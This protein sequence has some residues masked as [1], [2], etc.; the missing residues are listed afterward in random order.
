MSMRRAKGVRATIVRVFNTYGPTDAPRRRTR[1]PGA[2][3]ERAGRPAAGPPRRRQPDAL[4]LLRERPRRGAPA[5]RSGRRQ[6]RRDLQHRAIRQRSRSGSSPSRFANSSSPELSIV[7]IDAR[8]GDP[9]RRR[10]DISKVHARYGWE[11]NGG[12]WPWPQANDRGTRWREADRLAPALTVVV[13]RGAAWVVAE[14]DPPGRSA[15]TSHSRPCTSSPDGAAPGRNGRAIRGLIAASHTEL[16]VGTHRR[17]RMRLPTA[18][19]AG[20]SS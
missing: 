6:R 4:V 11:P 1:H 17:C 10:P 13:G 7:S 8:A 2:A 3:G 14:R 15:R 12:S 16:A 19:I 5:R 18:M 9:A 20:A